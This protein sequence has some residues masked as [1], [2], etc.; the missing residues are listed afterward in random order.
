MLPSVMQKELQALPL[1]PQLDPLYRQDS[2]VVD[3]PADTKTLDRASNLFSATPAK[4]PPVIRDFD[5][6]PTNPLAFGQS[7]QVLTDP[8]KL[9]LAELDTSSVTAS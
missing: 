5:N 4:R 7:P 8:G 3:Q 2:S 6:M 9:L 1:T